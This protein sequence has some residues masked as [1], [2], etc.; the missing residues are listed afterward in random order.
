M[1][2]TPTGGKVGKATLVGA[3]DAGTQIVTG[4]ATPPVVPA[5]G[6]YFRQIVLPAAIG[7]GG[8]WSWPADDP[9]WIG[10]GEAIQELVVCNLVA[11]ACSAFRCWAKFEN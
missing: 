2:V 5:G 6:P 8:V 10:D 1:S 7:A 9:L 4:W 11:V 3:A